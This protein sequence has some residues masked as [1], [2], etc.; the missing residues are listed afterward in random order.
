MVVGDE[1]HKELCEQYDVHHITQK[2]HPAT[3]KFNT[4]IE[5]LKT[6]DVDYSIITGS[7]DIMST[8]LLKNL[9][10]EMDNGYD[11]IGIS[12]VWFY[13]ADGQH[14]GK[15]R[16]LTTKGQLLG[17]ARCISKN[18]IERTGL[19]LW[20]K[21]ASWGMDGIALRNMQPHV[22]SFKFVQGMCVD[23]KTKENLNKMTMWLSRL[24]TAEDPQKFY[25][26]LS[27]EEK[28]ILAEI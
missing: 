10:K 1:D 22:K 20:N 9:I 8:D 15:L 5:Y 13:A 6:L 24:Q 7:D 19:P 16:H 11:L 14:E 17:V 27:D 28:Q 21:E 25:S 12:D 2:N 18:L 23:V 4:G 3:A 26:M